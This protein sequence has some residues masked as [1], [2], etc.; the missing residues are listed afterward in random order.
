MPSR[1]K[2]MKYKNK[3]MSKKLLS[4]FIHLVKRTKQL[5]LTLTNK[6]SRISLIKL[7]LKQ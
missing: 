5:L 3:K 6:V 1:K 2:K 7:S 4:M